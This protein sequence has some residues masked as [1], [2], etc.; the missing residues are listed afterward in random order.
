MRRRYRPFPLLRFAVGKADSGVRALS[1]PTVRDRVV[2]SAA[3]LVTRAV[4]EAEFEESSH[5]YRQGR[6]VRDGQSVYPLTKDVP[7]GSVVSPMLANLFL[8]ELDENLQLFGQAMV[9]Y[10]DDI[11][12]L[13]KSPAEAAQALEL[14]D[15]L[16]AQLELHLNRDKTRTTSFAQGFECLGAIFVKDSVFLPFDRHRPVQVPPVLP[17]PLDP[18]TYLELRAAR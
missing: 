15:Y 13:C 9:R 12:V 14:T 18:W 8:H 5:A 1:V 4:F 7:Q 6:S 3:Y 17:P 16:V 11:L 10:A 2:Q